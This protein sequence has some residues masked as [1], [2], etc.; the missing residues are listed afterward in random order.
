[1][2]TSLMWKS[3]NVKAIY[4]PALHSAICHH[5]SS[6]DL[7]SDTLLVSRVL[8]FAFRCHIGTLTPCIEA[9]A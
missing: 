1:M 2:L 8:L 3:I 9:V 7:V 4:L 5:V 6:V